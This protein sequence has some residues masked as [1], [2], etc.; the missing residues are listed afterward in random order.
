MDH[1]PQT[2]QEGCLISVGALTELGPTLVSLGPWL[3]SAGIS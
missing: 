3:G 2:S 1:K